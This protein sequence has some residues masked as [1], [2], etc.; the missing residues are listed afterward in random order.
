M[1]DYWVVGKISNQREF[2]IIIQQ[3]NANLKE[4][5]GKKDYIYN[6]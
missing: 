4:I 3:K 6:F 2:Y 1:N 5:H